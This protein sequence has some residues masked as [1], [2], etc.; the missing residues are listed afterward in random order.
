[1]TDL[2]AANGVPPVRE[3][4]KVTIFSPARTAMQSGSAQ[5]LQGK[6]NYNK[7]F[8]KNISQTFR[9]LCST[10]SKFL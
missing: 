6:L 1:M 5:T 3:G 4:R 2:L 10:K 8:F 9:L 7:K